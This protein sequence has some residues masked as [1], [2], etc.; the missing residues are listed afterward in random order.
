MSEEES[1][2]RREKIVSDHPLLFRYRSYFACGDGW[3][4]IIENLATKL[5]TLIQNFKKENP[6]VSD[7]DLPCCSDVK[8]KWGSLRFYMCGETPEMGQAIEEAEEASFNTCESCGKPGEMIITRGC[9]V[10]CEKCARE[11]TC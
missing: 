3:L 9:F 11:K 5:E 2:K 1:Q 8:Q 4:D 7:D 10:A 6:N